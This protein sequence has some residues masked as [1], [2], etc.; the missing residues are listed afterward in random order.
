MRT[1]L[2]GLHRIGHIMNGGIGSSSPCRSMSC[3]ISSAWL[4]DNGNSV[5]KR[6]DK[7]TEVAEIIGE[8]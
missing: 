6:T 1:V 4:P 8:E 2:W 5:E 3:P 7:Q